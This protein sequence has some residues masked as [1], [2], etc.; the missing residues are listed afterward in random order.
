LASLALLIRR[1]VDHGATPKISEALAVIQHAKAPLCFACLGLTERD[2]PSLVKAFGIDT[3]PKH[4][5]VDGVCGK[6]GKGTR[7]VRKLRA[8][9]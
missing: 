9:R 8:F 2:E 7:V 3:P 5:L 6:C 1:P 4:R